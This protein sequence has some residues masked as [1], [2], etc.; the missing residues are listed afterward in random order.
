MDFLK[1]VIL[2][3]LLVHAHRHGAPEERYMGC[4]LKVG[5]SLSGFSE[6]LC[7]CGDISDRPGTNERALSNLLAAQEVSFPDKRGL[8]S[9]VAFWGQFVDHDIVLTP[10]DDKAPP[11]LLDLDP[12]NASMTL[13]P[14]VMSAAHQDSLGFVRCNRTKNIVSPALDGSGIYGTSPQELLILKQPDVCELWAS[15]GALPLFVDGAFLCGDVRCGE[16]SVLT[17]LHGL[18]VAEHNFH[19]AQLRAR[20]LNASEEILFQKAQAI[21]KGVVQH[22]TVQE[23]LPALLGKSLLEKLQRDVPVKGKGLEIST[24]FSGAAFRFGHSAIPGKIGKYSL[25]EMFHNPSFIQSQEIGSKVLLDLAWRTKAEAVDI[26]I[27]DELRNFLF[28]V[29]HLLHGCCVF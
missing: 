28:K 2:I 3:P 29:F 24:E 10:E 19:C 16:N 23:W 11:V 7:P 27:V 26:F 5:S 20:S 15:G 9:L 25:V 8:S 22:I 12:F 1:M 17:A 6:T 14:S 13:H 4:T 21:T 18:F